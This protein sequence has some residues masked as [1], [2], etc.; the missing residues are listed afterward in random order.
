[1]KIE[2]PKLLPGEEFSHEL[3]RE[4]GEVIGVLMKFQNANFKIE[5]IVDLDLA[6]AAKF[7]MLRTRAQ[8]LIEKLR[9][10]TREKR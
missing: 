5:E 7:D 8:A 1:M 2:L 9:K 10:E 6:Y 4:D 3:V